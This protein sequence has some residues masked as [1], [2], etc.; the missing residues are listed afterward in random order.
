MMS[1]TRVAGPDRAWTRHSEVL[2][3]CTPSDHTVAVDD[4]ESE[5]SHTIRHL[6]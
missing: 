1:L 6:H 2:Y 4:A 3:A 5:V